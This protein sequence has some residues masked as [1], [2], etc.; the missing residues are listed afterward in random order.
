M[1]IQWQFDGDDTGG[2][3]TAYYGRCRVTQYA[4]GGM[5]ATLP[6][7]PTEDETRTRREL[8]ERYDK[9]GKIWVEGWKRRHK[10]SLGPYDAENPKVCVNCGMDLRRVETGAQCSGPGVERAR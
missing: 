8:F 1:N 9:T 4:N 3:V 5:I 10:P 7:Q 2:T 6:A